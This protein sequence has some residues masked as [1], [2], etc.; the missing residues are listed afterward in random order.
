MTTD[1]PEAIM[2]LS[3]GKTDDFSVCVD[4]DGGHILASKSSFAI[5]GAAFLSSSLFVLASAIALY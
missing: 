5:T 1:D 2:R 3:P 4:K